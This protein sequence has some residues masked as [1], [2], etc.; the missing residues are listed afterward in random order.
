MQG[1]VVN[2]LN[3]KTALFFLAFLPQF[4]DPSRGSAWLQ[5]AVLGCLFVVIALCSDIAYAL[6]ADALAGRFRRGGTIAQV[7]PVCTGGIFVALGLSAATAHRVRDAVPLLDDARIVVA[8]VDP[9]DSF[10]G[11]A[12]ARIAARTSPRGAR[13]ARLSA[14]GPSARAARPA[15]RHGDDRDRA[16]VAPDSR[17]PVRP[18]SRGDRDGLRT[19]SCGSA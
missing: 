2:I 3:P 16:T 14:R 5:I 15:G 1:V 19:S 11:R 17:G 8:E 7:S 10:C 6:L 12:A 18:A 4:V 13:R 9:D